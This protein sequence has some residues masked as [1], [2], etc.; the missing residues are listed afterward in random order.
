M[1]W[2]GVREEEGRKERK[3]D[4]RVFG[5]HYGIGGLPFPRKSQSLQGKAGSPMKMQCSGKKLSLKSLYSKTCV[6]FFQDSDKFFIKKGITV[7]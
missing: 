5:Q 2:V 7:E 3:G 6:L 4:P 1:V